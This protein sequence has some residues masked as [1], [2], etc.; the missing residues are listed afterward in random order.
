[1]IYAGAVT[2][3]MLRRRR[4]L[5]QEMMRRRVSGGAGPVAP[6]PK[7]T[8]PPYKYI[9]TPSYGQFIANE[10]RLLFAAIGRLVRRTPRA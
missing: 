1:M 8:A 9:H 2:V 6:P 7:A 4:Q 10:F 3:A 5:A